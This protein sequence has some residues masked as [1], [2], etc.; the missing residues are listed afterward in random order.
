MKRLGYH[1]VDNRDCAIVYINGDVL[2]GQV[3]PTM[4]EDYLKQHNLLDE[5]NRNFLDA[6]GYSESEKEEQLDIAH[7][8]NELVDDLS[9]ALSEFGRDEY[10]LEQSTDIPLAFAHKTG[11]DIFI[12]SDAVYNMRFM[13]LVSELKNRYPECAFYTDE[14]E[15]RVASIRL[16]KHGIMNRDEAVLYIE[17][18]VLCGNNHPKLIGEW[19]CSQNNIR[20]Y[21]EKFYQDIG[22]DV[23]SRKVQNKIDI[24]IHDRDL[25]YEVYAMVMEG[26]RQSVA[27]GDFEMGF[28][29][30]CDDKIFLETQ[31]LFNVDKDKVISAIKSKFPDYPIFDDDSY[32][33]IDSN[34]ENYIRLAFKKKK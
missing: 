22:E 33:N 32:S 6:E 29:H 12:I 16:G 4:V 18:D 11:N 26:K 17:G 7:Q 19:M 30:L 23:S 20:E 31:S 27:A 24:A 34:P 3:H 10:D 14:D 15:E 25:P 1:G 8:R 9:Y 21:L 2:E 13:D 28:A 5:I